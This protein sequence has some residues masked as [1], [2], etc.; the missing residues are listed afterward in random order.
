[1]WCWT[2]CFTLAMSHE[3]GSC[4][5]VV[6]GGARIVWW[7]KGGR[8]CKRAGASSGGL[9]VAAL[10]AWRGGVSSLLLLILLTS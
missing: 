6:L 7:A 1:M 3:F 10:G 2:Q 5:W 4:V 8:R 9:A